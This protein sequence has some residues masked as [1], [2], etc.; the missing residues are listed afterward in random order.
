L[1]YTLNFFKYLSISLF[2]LAGWAPAESGTKNQDDF[3]LA[4][5]KQ[6]I[7]LGGCVLAT[8]PEI[9]FNKVSSEP[10]AILTSSQNIVR[11]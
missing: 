2:C 11:V 5:L 1:S 4:S 7:V 8:A 3:K 9:A 6:K 10:G